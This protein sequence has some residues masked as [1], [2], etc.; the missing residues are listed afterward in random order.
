MAKVNGKSNGDSA[1]KMTIDFP[2]FFNI[3]T[4]AT[5]S[6]ISG[7]I[8]L[9]SGVNFIRLFMQ[10]GSGEQRWFFLSC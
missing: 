1:K 10:P 2:V 7:K 5:G 4:L 3:Y 8:L 6:S 9:P